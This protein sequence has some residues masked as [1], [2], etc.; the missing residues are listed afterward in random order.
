MIDYSKIDSNCIE[1]VEFFNSIGLTTSQSCEGHISRSMYSYYIQFDKSVSDS[2]IENFILKFE[3]PLYAKN[4]IKGKFVKIH[5]GF[6]DGKSVSAWRYWCNI[7]CDYKMNQFF[8]KE[9]LIIF[10]DK[11]NYI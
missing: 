9:D 4:K 1:F 3:Q 2:D 11:F 7:S 10:K 6:I 5:F 8:A